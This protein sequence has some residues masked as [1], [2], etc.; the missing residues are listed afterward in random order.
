MAGMAKKNLLKTVMMN[1]NLRQNVSI[2]Y[3]GLRQPSPLRCSELSR[4]VLTSFWNRTRNAPDFAH[5][6]GL[7]GNN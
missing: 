6:A 1:V 3:A 7:L 4:I 2:K 5:D